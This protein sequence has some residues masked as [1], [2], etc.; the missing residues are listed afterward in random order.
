MVRKITN[1]G[2]FLAK[3]RLARKLLFNPQSKEK[4][5]KTLQKAFHLFEEAAPHH[6][7]AK[8]AQAAMLFAGEGVAKQIDEAIRIFAELTN[9]EDK[10][11]ASRA[12]YNLGL[13]YLKEKNDLLTAIQYFQL[14]VS[15]NEA[16]AQLFMAWLYEFGLGV[17]IKMK[18][19]ENLLKQSAQIYEKGQMELLRF[20]ERQY[21]SKA[22]KK[23]DYE[24]NILEAKKIIP[25]FSREE[26]QVINI[27]MLNPF[28]EK[29]ESK[30]EADPFFIKI[31]KT[32]VSISQNKKLYRYQKIR[33][34]FANISIA[35]ELDNINIVTIL[36]SIGS[37][38]AAFDH[39]PQV[40]STYV[41]EISKIIKK[42]LI[43]V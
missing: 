28:E 18:R 42:Y 21:Q 26:H 38:F 17:K 31:N 23:L 4:D 1:Q 3:D 32:V 7:P 22:M 16:N 33:S 24:K 14:A 11:M 20:Y 8:V 34:I 9:G 37:L 2:F 40:I 35:S 29:G 41:N 43:N 12:K 5:E 36:N 30:K 39:L 27:E 19:A 13:I 10:E 25:K 6:P 15:E